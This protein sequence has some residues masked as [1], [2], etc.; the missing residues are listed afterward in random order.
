MNDDDLR[1]LFRRDPP[2]EPPVDLR[3]RAH[4]RLGGVRRRRRVGTALGAV[5][6]VLVAAVVLSEVLPSRPADVVIQPGGDPTPALAEAPVVS[7]GDTTAAGGSCG[8]TAPQGGRQG[9]VGDL[10]GDGRGDTVV[11]SGGTVQVQ[12]A[13]GTTPGLPSFGT[14]AAAGA[15]DADGDGRV[16]LFLDRPLD[17]ADSPNALYTMLR[18]DGCELAYVLNEEGEPYAFEVGPDG[19]ALQG[20]GCVDVDGDG[21]TELVGTR[22]IL[23][24]ATGDYLVQRTPVDIAGPTAVNG[25]VEQVTVAGDGPGVDTLSTATCGDELI[26]TVP[27]V[28]G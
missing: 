8:G 28:E 22:A 18:L 20:V 6:A 5:A 11:V 2:P 10:D 25:E 17:G 16:E 15:V 14:I 23:D 7:E 3:E 4:R 9:V 13:A 26:A 24:P 27:L 1:D 21:A 19:D 12:G